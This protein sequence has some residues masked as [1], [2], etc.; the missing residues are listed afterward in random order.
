MDIEMRTW[1]NNLCN[2][3]DILS[4]SKGKLNNKHNKIGKKRCL[5]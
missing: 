5:K 1:K 4:T 2:D 3:W